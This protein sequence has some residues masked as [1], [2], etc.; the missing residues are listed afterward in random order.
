MTFGTFT[1]LY[2]H[3]IINFRTFSSSFKD[4]L[5]SSSTTLYMVP[6]GTAAFLVQRSLFLPPPLYRNPLREPSFQETK[7]KATGLSQAQWGSYPLRQGSTEGLDSFSEG[8]RAKIPAGSTV[9]AH[10]YVSR[11]SWLYQAVESSSCNGS[12]AVICRGV[13]QTFL[14]PLSRKK[15]FFAPSLNDPMGTRWG[16]WREKRGTSLGCQN[17][18]KFPED[19]CPF[20]P[21]L[22][23]F[24]SS[25]P[26]RIG[27]FDYKGFQVT[28]RTITYHKSS[29]NARPQGACNI[30]QALEG[31]WESRHF[32]DQISLSCHYLQ[33]ES[34]WVYHWWPYASLS[35]L[36]LRP[37]LPQ[38]PKP[39]R[40]A[41]CQ[42]LL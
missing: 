28:L 41:S 37:W 29:P 15:A 35:L 27:S 7:A 30:V 42:A 11:V 39:Q 13:S 34:Q 12:R 33:Q 18:R 5:C 8:Y 26:P 2:N 1:E 10:Q 36:L 31:V 32:D 21:H 9:Q 40:G 24:V 38:P 14:S 20:G 6:G 17:E 23:L 16:V 22:L 19:L 3:H 25:L 4:P